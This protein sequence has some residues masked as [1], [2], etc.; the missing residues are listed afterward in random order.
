V[1]LSTLCEERQR[2]QL[3]GKR[4]VLTNGCFDLLH[5]GHLYLL[6]RA[7]QM[8]DVLVVALNSD[9]S[10][11]NLKGPDRPILSEE[12][13]AYTLGCTRFVERI[14][15]FDGTRVTE[16]IRCLAPDVYVRAA[17]RSP[18]NLDSKE[19]LALREVGAQIEFVPF[20]SNFSTTGIIERLRKNIAYPR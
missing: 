18:V 12:M 9:A 20:L 13:R 4:L 8:G 17:D 14:F 6:E 5:P 2:W 15:I 3:G 19:L 11:R 1:S 16:E 7:A 10:V